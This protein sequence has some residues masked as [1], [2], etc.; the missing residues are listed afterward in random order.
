MDKIRLVL[1]VIATALP[2]IVCDVLAAMWAKK[3]GA[4]IL[5]IL[6]ALSP[7]GY[8][9]FA[10]VNKKMSLSMSTGWVSV[11]IVVGTIAVGFFYFGDQLEFRHKIA[12]MLII[13]AVF[14]AA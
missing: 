12:L 6:I 10:Y 5:F 14:V 13:V 7:V 3:G 1:L 4:K 11:A 9:L 2:F 8:I